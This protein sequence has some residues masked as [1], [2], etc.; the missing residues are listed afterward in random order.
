MHE[1]RVEDLKSRVG[2]FIRAIAGGL[3]VSLAGTLPWAWL[4]SANFKFLPSV[5]WSVPPTLIY[6]WLFWAVVSGKSLPRLGGSLRRESLR[7]NPVPD[8]LWGPALVAGVLG[9]VTVVLVQGLIVR[10][11]PAHPAPAAQADLGRI[12]FL[13]LALMLPA[14]AAVS[15]IVEEAAFRGYLQGPLERGFG[16]LLAIMITGLMFGFAHFTHPQVTASWLPY[17]MT[18]AAVYGGVAYFTNSIYPSMLLHGGGNL[19]AS[20]PLLVAQGAEGSGPSSQV[21]FTR[22]G[23]PLWLLC[24]ELLVSILLTGLAFRALSKA[25][26]ASTAMDA[27]VES[28]ATMRVRSRGA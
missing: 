20:L 16:P 9:L 11:A 1:T 18:V 5:P 6:L 3:L 2:L 23:Q 10:L 27:S 21:T 14:G 4:S 24:L 25:A 22:G 19:L 7:A 15:G 17:Y 12:S 28:E 13:T 26:Q 8:R